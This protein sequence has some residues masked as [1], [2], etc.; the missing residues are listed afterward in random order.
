MN[1]YMSNLVCE[2]FSSCSTEILSWKCWNAKKK[3]WWHHTSVLYT[4]VIH[5]LGMCW[6][7][8]TLDCLAHGWSKINH[9][10]HTCAL[11]K[12]CAVIVLYLSWPAVS[13]ENKQFIE[14]MVR[15]N[16]GRKIETLHFLEELIYF[17]VIDILNEDHISCSSQANC[18]SFWENSRP[19]SLRRVRAITCR[20]SP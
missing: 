16:V 3:I 11:L 1:Q 7:L 12:Y 20:C 17:L 2:G 19:L 5:F 10:F 15:S 18:H 6:Y 4:I 9:K 14:W 13:L 8:S